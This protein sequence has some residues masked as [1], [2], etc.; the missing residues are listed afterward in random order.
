MGVIRLDGLPV[1]Q[2]EAE[3]W[4]IDEHTIRV[5]EMFAR[6]L[7]TEFATGVRGLLHD[8]E[9]GISAQ[10]GE[11][12]LE[13]IAGAM[14]ALNELKERTLAQAI[15][16]R[17]R[18][19]LEPMIETRLDWAA[20]T[21]GRLAQRAAVEVDDQSVAE[22]IAGLNQDAAMA[23]RDPAYLRRLGRTAVEELRYQ[24]ER[25][26]WDLAE[27]DAKARGGLSD[28]YAGAVETAIGQDDLDGAAALYDHARPA[29]D[30]VRQA[31]LDRRFVQAR[32]VALYRDVDRD[33]AGIPIDPA[34]PPAAEVFA[35]R[36]AELTPEDASDAMRA[37]IGQVADFAQRRAERQWNRQQA[38]VGVAA[39][40]WLG[41]NPDRSFLAIP[42]GIR[43]WLALDQ[44]RGL[45]TFY[46]DGR[47]RTDRDL[48]E[49]LDRQMI[50][51]PSAFAGVDLDRHRLS[52]DDEDH[53]RFAAAQKAIAEG[54]S[55]PA[56]IRYRRA[57]LDAD[58]TME[59]KGIDTNGPAAAVIREDIRDGLDGFEAIEGRPP[60]G[61]DIAAIVSK[62]VDGDA[63][64]MEAPDGR[65]PGEGDA[66]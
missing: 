61:E 23:W 31:A 19:I 64:P 14:P 13:A 18:S 62:E 33:M 15:G 6:Q 48:F 16:P 17:Q 43:D 25:R 11:A 53:A 3:P 59:T 2:P 1:A 55:D 41:Q 32:E 44:W 37:G 50:Y 49:Q 35:Q 54:I 47:L 38:E 45:E 52:L 51:E 21:L 66:Y 57:R 30:T 58:R 5:D 36:A 63:S 22:R 26:G 29:I 56:F 7:D 40:D 10:N 4:P 9:T 34:G 12:A 46:I 42:S 28:L 24:G 8:P 39:L 60:N 27:I 20:G 65:Y